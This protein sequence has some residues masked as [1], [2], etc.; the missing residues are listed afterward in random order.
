MDIRP[1]QEHRLDAKHNITGGIEH[2]H[3]R[4]FGFTR[5][6]FCSDVCS[7]SSRCGSNLYFGSV[8]AQGSDSCSAIK[9]GF[10]I[11]VT[12]STNSA[13]ANTCYFNIIIQVTNSAGVPTRQY[14]T[15]VLSPNGTYTAS[16][17]SLFGTF[18]SL[19]G[20]TPARSRS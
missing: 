20:L 7:A 4:T 5:D 16:D 8:S 2:V 18:F 3:E 9:G 19:Q 13:G 15:D 11:Q 10:P 17:P 1:A 6:G 14:L 12:Y